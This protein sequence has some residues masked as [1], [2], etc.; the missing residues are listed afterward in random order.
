MEYVFGFSIQLVS[1]T[2]LILR[3][4]ERNIV[5]NVNSSSSTVPV[6]IVRF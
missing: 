2:F 3:R 5:A 4:I 6:I 1:E